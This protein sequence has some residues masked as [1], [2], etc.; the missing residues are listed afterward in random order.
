MLHDEKDYLDR[1]PNEA[2]NRSKPQPVTWLSAVSLP[3]FSLENDL[4]QWSKLL[5]SDGP[6]D[7]E[8][9]TFRRVFPPSF[10]HDQYCEVHFFQQALWSPSSIAE[11]SLTTNKPAS[12]SL[13]SAGLRGQ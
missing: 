2:E 12:H 11:G 9:A 6:T 4:D 3:N 13:I 5:N 1:Q 10:F 8:E 7:L